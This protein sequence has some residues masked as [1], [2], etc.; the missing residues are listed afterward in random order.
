MTVPASKK[1][2]PPSL[3]AVPPP[4]PDVISASHPPPTR[5]HLLHLTTSTSGCLCLVC[6]PTRWILVGGVDPL[7]GCKSQWKVLQTGKTNWINFVRR[8]TFS[9]YLSNHKK[10][11]HSRDTWTTEISH[12]LTSWN[13]IDYHW[14]SLIFIDDHL[15]SLIIIDYHWLSENLKKKEMSDN[16][17]SRDAS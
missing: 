1:R 9:T 10:N 14:L 2:K 4:L 15:L 6:R 7:C 17:K 13:I 11:Y 12:Q 3:V 8:K 5:L 16:L